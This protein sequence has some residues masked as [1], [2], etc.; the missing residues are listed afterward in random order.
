MKGAR[1]TYN[2]CLEATKK[3]GLPLDA[4]ILRDK[5]VTERE[6]KIK[7]KPADT[8]MEVSAEMQKQL[9]MQAARTA[10][11]KQY[12]IE[13]GKFIRDNRFLKTTPQPIRDAAVRDLV[14]AADSN[15]AKQVARR[16]RGEKPKKYKI[17][18]R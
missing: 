15:A 17:H 7:I 11:R 9:D 16:E 13:V 14:K 18:F 8:Q 2:K 1:Y 5:F 3:Q 10:R 6:K 4:K 12:N